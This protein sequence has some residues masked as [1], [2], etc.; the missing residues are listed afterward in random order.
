MFCVPGIGVSISISMESSSSEMAWV[1]LKCLRFLL[2]A[3]P[4]G[5]LMMYDRGSEQMSSTTAGFQCLPHWNITLS[6]L[7]R[8]DK[9]LECRS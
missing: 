2:S 3:C 1:S 5:V 8:S 7:L 6:P 9:G 4:S